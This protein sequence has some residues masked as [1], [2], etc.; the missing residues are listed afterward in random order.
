MKGRRLAVLVVLVLGLAAC[1]SADTLGDANQTTDAVT[2]DTQPSAPVTEVTTGAGEQATAT[3]S[4]GSPMVTSSPKATPSTT[5]PPKATPSA[6]TSAPSTGGGTVDPGL[7]P[8]VDK[9]KADLAGRLGVDAGTIV[10]VSAE[11]VVWPDLSLGCPKP[12]MVYQP[13][14]TDGSVIVLSSGGT[15]YRYHTGGSEYVPFLCE[16]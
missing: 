11:L 3:T 15:E 8:F 4:E 7:L 6:T 2:G 13:A 9:A 5:S 1:G 14:P 16:E 10:L 12:G